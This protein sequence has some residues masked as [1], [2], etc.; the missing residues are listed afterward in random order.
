MYTGI[1]AKPKTAK[2]K[3]NNRVLLVAGALG[4]LVAVGLLLE[5]RYLAVNYPVAWTVSTISY[6]Y[7]VA[8]YAGI[9]VLA[10]SMILIVIYVFVGFVT[11]S[12]P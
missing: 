6:W 2:I 5:A 9:T 12:K 1:M 10:I 8:R 4:L 11:E 3:T 7:W